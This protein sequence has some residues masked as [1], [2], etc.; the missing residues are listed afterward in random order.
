MLTRS[1]SRGVSAGVGVHSRR[2]ETEVGVP[3]RAAKGDDV[4]VEW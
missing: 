3:R 1:P 4:P 2:E